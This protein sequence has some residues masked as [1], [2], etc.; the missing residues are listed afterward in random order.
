MSLNHNHF[1]AEYISNLMF[2]KMMSLE[3]I[4]EVH[5]TIPA[6]IL[7]AVK[8]FIPYASEIGCIPLQQR[9][10]MYISAKFK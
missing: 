8:L 9:G 3:L 5:R 6:K 7:V 4:A 10:G 1:P 2:L